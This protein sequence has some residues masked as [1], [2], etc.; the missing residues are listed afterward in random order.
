M[1]RSHMTVGGDI[2]PDL[3]KL[4]WFM[5]ACFGIHF[6]ILPLKT[7]CNFA[8]DLLLKDLNSGSRHCG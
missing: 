5:A 2:S 3:L 8:E 6:L 4:K 1:G 7:R